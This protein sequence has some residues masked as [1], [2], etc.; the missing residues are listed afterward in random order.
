[1]LPT[2]YRT[3]DGGQH[4]AVVT[5]S[6]DRADP[7]VIR[8]GYVGVGVSISF[9]DV[10]D[11][12]MSSQSML[13]STR[14][15]GRTWQVVDLHIPAS[16]QFRLDWV[17]APVSNPDGSA[18]IVAKLDGTPGMDG[19]KGRQVIYTSANRGESWKVAAT[20]DDPGSLTVSLMSPSTWIAMDTLNG[21]TV[22]ATKNSGLPWRTTAIKARWQFTATSVSFADVDHG[23]LAVIEPNPPCPSMT[24]PSG[25]VMHVSCDYAFLPP[26]HL[27]ATEDGGATWHEVLH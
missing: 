18:V 19:A 20:L 25:G 7:G 9:T 24:S 15:A 6:F 27:W 22:Q 23:W 14:D 4:W 10:N 11:G 26:Q 3:D 8:P 2:L 12:L 1:M 16:S 5:D 21:T 17:S 13:W